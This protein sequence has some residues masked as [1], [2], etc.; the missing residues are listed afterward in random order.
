MEEWLKLLPPERAN[1]YLLRLARHE[2]VLSRLF[3]QKLCTLARG[4]RGGATVEGEQVPF[5]ALRDEANGRR[6][7]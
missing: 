3:L 7:S 2:P 4:P 6:K 5:A 1:G